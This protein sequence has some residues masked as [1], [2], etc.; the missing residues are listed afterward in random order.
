M[1]SARRSHDRDRATDS[2]RPANRRKQLGDFGEQAVASW[3]TTRGATILDRNW[4]VREGEIDLIA[5]NAGVLSIVEVKTRSSDRYGSP[6]EAITPTKA[7][8]LRRLA[9]MWLSSRTDLR[10]ASIQ[11]DVASVTIDKE[12]Q[13]VIEVLTLDV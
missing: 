4:R 1:A 12:G 6:F 8:R 7:A 5:L 9:G 2:A 10:Y 11:I 13:P 3:Y